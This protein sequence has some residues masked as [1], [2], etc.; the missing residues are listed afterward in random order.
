[1]RALF[2]LT[3]YK[4]MMRCKCAQASNKAEPIHLPDTI[5]R[6]GSAKNVLAI[7]TPCTIEGERN[8][9]DYSSSLECTNLSGCISASCVSRENTCEIGSSVT[10]IQGPT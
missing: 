5:R 7:W 2:N 1:M 9:P 4:R 3:L 10:K 8:F 6:E